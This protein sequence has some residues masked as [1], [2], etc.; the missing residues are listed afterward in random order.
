[1]IILFHNSPFPDWPSWCFMLGIGGEIYVTNKIT[2]LVPLNWNMLWTCDIIYDSWLVENEL[3]L[4]GRWYFGTVKI[5]IAK[6]RR[7]NVSHSRARKHTR[8][9]R[10]RTHAI[11]LELISFSS[12]NDKIVNK[13]SSMF[14]PLYKFYHNKLPINGVFVFLTYPGLNNIFYKI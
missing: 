14:H 4:D 2:I 5:I 13:S 6:K 1:M 3:S 12:P 10:T 8:S 9:P 7:E 11:W